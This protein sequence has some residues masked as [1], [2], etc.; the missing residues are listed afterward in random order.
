MKSI[1]V[2]II[3]DDT[4]FY[5]LLNSLVI[6][7]TLSKLN[8]SIIL[9]ANSIIQTKMLKQLGYCPDIIILDLNI[10]DSFGMATFKKISAEFNHS[11]VIIV[12]SIEEQNII[13]EL[14]RKGAKEYIIKDRLNSDTLKSAI[15]ECLLH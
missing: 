11:S 12:S 5:R 13:H 6:S 10:I 4:V 9:R 8:V 15:E 7:S 3:E 1:N 14:K 2:L